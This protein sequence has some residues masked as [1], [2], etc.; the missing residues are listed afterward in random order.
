MDCK[1]N[2]VK[3]EPAVPFLDTIRSERKSFLR[4]I[5]T[6]EKKIIVDGVVDITTATYCLSAHTV[7]SFYLSLVTLCFQAIEIKSAPSQE[8][9]QHR[10]QLSLVFF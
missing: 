7:V 1:T 10:K 5:S 4:L 6:S 8:A 3:S 2:D 9:Q